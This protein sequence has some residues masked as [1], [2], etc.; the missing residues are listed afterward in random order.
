MMEAVDICKYEDTILHTIPWTLVAPL[1]VNE[2]F[3]DLT[4]EQKTMYGSFGGRNCKNCK[5]ELH[6]AF[7]PHPCLDGERGFFF[8]SFAP[9]PRPEP[10]ETILECSA[11]TKNME[12]PI[13]HCKAVLSSAWPPLLT[14][15]TFHRPIADPKLPF[16]AHRSTRHTVVRWTAHHSLAT[17]GAGRTVLDNGPHVAHHLFPKDDV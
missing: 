12:N 1:K 3:L 15:S 7:F 13:P 2:G 4:G 6:G 14:C 10:G 11:D 8:L 9:P 16:A 17:L 5:K